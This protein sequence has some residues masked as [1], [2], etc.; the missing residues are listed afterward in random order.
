MRKAISLATVYLDV[1]EYVDDKGETHID[2]DQTAT[3]GIKGTSEKRVLD[4]KIPENTHKDGIF[5]EVEGVYD[6]SLSY[7]RRN[8]P[9]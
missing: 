2:I 5:G 8:L 4:W 6:N 9:C 3:G 1:K 7:P